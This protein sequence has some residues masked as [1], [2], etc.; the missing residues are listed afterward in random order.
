[1]FVM[2]TT[3]T[4]NRLFKIDLHADNTTVEIHACE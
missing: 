1:M 3:D 4:C 2:A